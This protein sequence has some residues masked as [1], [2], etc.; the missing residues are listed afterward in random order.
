MLQY[1]T[2]T[3]NHLICHIILCI[4]T[5]LVTGIGRAE[6]GTWDRYFGQ[7]L[8]ILLEKI[9]EPPSSSDYHL[10]SSGSASKRRHGGRDA[11]AACPLLVSACG[12]TRGSDND[13]EWSSDRKDSLASNPR[14][15]SLCGLH[16][17]LSKAPD[18]FEGMTLF[19]SLLLSLSC[20]FMHHVVPH[21]LAIYLPT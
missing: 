1:Q 4:H 14:F 11:A 6:R 10:S 18:Y 17:L 15:T 5:Q 16:Y 3:A 13:E 7:T 8:H 19:T 2:D 20:G 21:P 12:G 9:R